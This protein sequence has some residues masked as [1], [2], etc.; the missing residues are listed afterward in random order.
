M[1]TR[2]NF[3]NDATV[4][5]VLIHGGRGPVNQKITATHQ[6]DTCLIAGGFNSQ[7]QGVFFTHPAILVR[8]VMMRIRRKRDGDDPEGSSPNQ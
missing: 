4:A 1:C 3:R 7:Y 8:L 2:G 5:G 6:G